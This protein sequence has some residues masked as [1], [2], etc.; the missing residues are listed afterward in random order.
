MVVRDDPAAVQALETQ[1][2]AHPHVDLGAA[3]EGAGDAIEERRETDVTGGGDV[4]VVNV[5]PDV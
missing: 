3:G 5:V 4:E 1:G 2:G